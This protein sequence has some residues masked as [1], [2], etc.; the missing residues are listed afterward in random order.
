MQHKPTTIGSAQ[1]REAV[2]LRPQPRRVPVHGYVQW[3]RSQDP[4]TRRDNRGNA[5]QAAP[6]AD[7][8]NRRAFFR[9]RR[10][11]APARATH[12]AGTDGEREVNVARSPPD[13]AALV[14]HASQRV[15]K[16][17]NIGHPAIVAVFGLRMPPDRLSGESY[18]V[19]RP[20]RESPPA[21]SGATPRPTP[22]LPLFPSTSVSRPPLSLGRPAHRP[23]G[24]STS[25]S[26]S[27]SA[28][29]SRQFRISAEAC[30]PC[31][32][33]SATERSISEILL[34]YRM[35]GGL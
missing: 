27:A 11:P 12:A 32:S 5:G 31:R 8:T 19:N 28:S 23:R 35:W 26:A 15:D 4:S 6:N 20:V 25:A 3:M 17:S 30:Q 33:S 1:P 9:K 34:N 21:P 16:L 29:A 13:Q 22:P 7:G 14:R 2:R 24:N 18:V 10:V